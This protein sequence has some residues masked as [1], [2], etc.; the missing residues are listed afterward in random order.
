MTK[1]YELSSDAT[2]LR[3]QK[4]KNFYQTIVQNKDNKQLS[5]FRE[6]IRT[7]QL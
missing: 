5:N 7:E 2:L 3:G 6:I 4:L 1:I